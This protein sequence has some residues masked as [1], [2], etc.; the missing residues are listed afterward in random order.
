MYTQA[1]HRYVK[2]NATCILFVGSL[3]YI[4]ENGSY[5]YK[6]FLAE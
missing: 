5:F 3:E 1:T 6:I 2:N 4:V